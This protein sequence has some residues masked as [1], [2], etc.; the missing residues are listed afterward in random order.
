MNVEYHHA[1]SAH[2]NQDMEMKVYGHAGKPVVVFPAQGGRFYDFENFGMIAAASRFIEQGF[3]RFYTVDSVDNQA[4]AN[5][6]SHPA[7]RGRRHEAYDRYITQEAAAFI[8]QHS[9]SESLFLATGVSMGGYHAANFFFRHPDIFD[10]VISLSGILQLKMFTGDYVD[11]C[12]YFNSPLLYL[13]NLEDAWYLEKY[14]RSQII[15]CAGQGAW[16]ETMNADMR[17][18]KGILEARQVPAWIDLWGQDVNHDWP[19]WQK[20]LPYFLSTLLELPK[21]ASSALL[22]AEAP[23]TNRKENRGEAQQDAH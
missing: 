3:F 4:W 20:Q 18:L 12:V 19:W 1:W 11:D 21:G 23:D 8:H 9:Q 6:H 10:S 15:I 22:V 13:S 14:R 17:A 16:E 5:W 7:E 2:L